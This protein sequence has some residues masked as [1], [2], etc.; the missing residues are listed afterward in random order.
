VAYRH[1]WNADYRSSIY[2]GQLEIDETG[3]DRKHWGVNL[4]RSL[5]KKISVG[6]EIGNYETESG[7]SNYFQVSAKFVL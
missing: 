4:I 5:T 3:A 7:D 1:K 6:A 2:Y